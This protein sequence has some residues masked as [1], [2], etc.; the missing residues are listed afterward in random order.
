MQLYNGCVIIKA[1]I[2]DWG[3][4]MNSEVQDYLCDLEKK[5]DKAE[6]VLAGTMLFTTIAAGISSIAA[7]MG[8]TAHCCAEMAFKDISRDV[9]DSNNFQNE[10]VLKKQELEDRYHLGNIT[11]EEYASGKDRLYSREAII[12]YA[13]QDSEFK[14]F[15]DA[16]QQSRDCADV[17][18][19]KGMPTVL[20]ITGVGAAATTVSAIIKRRYDRIINEYKSKEEKVM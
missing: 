7:V 18:L 4:K 13:T 14:S 6:S 17:T 9:V 15:A 3:D 19:G 2:N 8:V 5:K 12:D 20:G 16:Y 1:L 10:I 11:F